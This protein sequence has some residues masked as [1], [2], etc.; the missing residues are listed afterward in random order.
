MA[1]HVLRANQP[2][3]KLPRAGTARLSSN[4]PPSRASRHLHS[5]DSS[6]LSMRA[7]KTPRATT[8]CRI[9]PSPPLFDQHLTF[10]HGGNYWRDTYLLERW[11][12]CEQP[13]VYLGRTYGGYELRLRLGDWCWLTR[14]PVSGAHM[15]VKFLS[16]SRRN[17]LPMAQFVR[18]HSS[19]PYLCIIRDH[20]RI[21]HHINSADPR[22]HGVE[23]NAIVYPTTGT[24]LRRLSTPGE[25]I[26]GPDLPL[27]PAR[28]KR[29][30]RDL[31]RGLVELHDMGIVHGDIHPGN[32]ALPPP[33]G[34]EIEDHLARESPL[35]HEVRRKDGQPTHPALPTHVTEPVDIGFG[36]GSAK[37][38]D[39]G[40]SFRPADGGQY[41]RSHFPSGTMLPPELLDQDATT[42]FP[43]KVDSWHL[44]LCIFFIL[45]D[46]VPLMQCAFGG[47]VYRLGEYEER[48]ASLDDPEC[49]EMNELIPTELQESRA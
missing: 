23:F 4:T 5:T 15:T 47:C 36:E 42:S 44:G 37:I 27:T 17:E 3:F 38:L 7:S 29:C 14:D 11:A 32:I 30:V 10:T 20:F 6:R 24:D 18:D 22:Y 25:H 28:R 41:S 34:D 33:P 46:G 40:Y 26:E 19:S 39:L 21:P 35:V 43:F 2:L 45:T 9:P 48:I 49:V 8:T 16:R 13:V 1:P 12:W 31:V